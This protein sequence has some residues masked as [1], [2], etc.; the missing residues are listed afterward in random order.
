[1][2]G[3]P[4]C[5]RLLPNGECRQLPLIETSKMSTL[6]EF[7]ESSRTAGTWTTSHRVGFFFQRTIALSW[8]YERTPV[9]WYVVLE[10]ICF[11]I[12]KREDGVRT[13]VTVPWKQR[14]ATRLRTVRPE[15]LNGPHLSRNERQKTSRSDFSE[16]TTKEEDHKASGY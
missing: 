4:N 15:N 13:F 3:T 14:S 5:P 12:W 8:N 10:C 6:S 2:Q 1:M 16:S 7:I 9:V 11:T